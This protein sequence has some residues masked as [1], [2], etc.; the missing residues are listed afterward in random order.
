MCRPAYDTLRG[1]FPA[2][3]GCEFCRDD[4][5]VFALNRRAA[6][7][8]GVARGPG[9]HRGEPGEG[10]EPGRDRRGGDGGLPEG[11]D[12]AALPQVDGKARR[13]GDPSARRPA[14]VLLRGRSRDRP[15]AFSG[16]WPAAMLVAGI[17]LSIAA[18]AAR[19]VFIAAGR[20]RARRRA[21]PRGITRR[22]DLC[23]PLAG[24]TRQRSTSCCRE[25][26]DDRA[27][28]RRSSRR[29]RVSAARSRRGFPRGQALDAGSRL[30]VEG[31]LDAAAPGAWSSPTGMLGRAGGHARAV[32]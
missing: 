6:A 8:R 10:P 2:F 23:R 13:R 29:R 14:R 21:W 9:G 25:P 32:T 24:R 30:A 12:G 31:R 22:I 16:P 15:L 27:A 4:I 28:S 7:V 1:N 17:A 11:V 20:P 18:S 19:T 26:V 5:F 3:C